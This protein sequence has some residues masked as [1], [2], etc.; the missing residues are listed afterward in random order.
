MAD[1]AAPTI[2]TSQP[3]PTS[4]SHAEGAFGSLSGLS[5]PFTSDVQRLTFV[6]HLR[7]STV[8]RLADHDPDASAVKPLLNCFDCSCRVLVFV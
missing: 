3:N 4:E 2:D 6:P 7:D 5:K 8:I 1:L